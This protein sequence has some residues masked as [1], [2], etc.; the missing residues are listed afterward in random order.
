MK[1]EKTLRR[2]LETV[3]LTLRSNTVGG[4]RCQIGLFIRYLRKK[5][6]EISSF[7]QLQRPH[8]E[9]WLRCLARSA[10][11][12]S[13]RREKILKIRAFLGR[14]Q[15]W[16]WKE[17]PKAPLFFPGDLPPP[18]RYLPRPLSEESDRALKKY[19]GE[20]SG[21]IP[22]ALLL[23]RATGLRCQELLDL[24]I[25]ALK[26]YSADRWALHVPLGKLHSERVIP[27]DAGTVK[28]F[29]AICELRKGAPAVVDPET[30]KPAHFLVVR[31][32]GQRPIPLSLRYHLRKAEERAQLKE[33]PT[34]HR[35]RH[36]FATEMLRNGMSLPVL[37]KLLGHRTIDMTLRYAEVTGVD[38]QRAYLDTMA[39]IERRYE[40]PRLPLKHKQPDKRSAR[41]SIRSN[42]DS[43]AGELEAFRRDH[44][45]E[46][47]HKRIQRLVER[48]RR[49]ARD[50]ENL[51]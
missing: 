50:F 21:L 27:V 28:I 51:A 17:A 35:L 7:S 6:P 1:L 42:L 46:S 38:V 49:V 40:M 23:L 16:G 48:L 37:M 29:E 33:H 26:N 24:K 5:H 2:Y 44:A 34:P 10:L 20:R 3:A 25:D 32:D 4:Y 9:A 15:T 8:I 31:P 39:A 41:R 47:E 45:Q 36:T 11:R 43:L 14:I 12:Q 30:G 19:L 13:A 22:R 18:D